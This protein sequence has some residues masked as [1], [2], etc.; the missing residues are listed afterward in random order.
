MKPANVFIQL[1]TAAVFL[2]SASAMAADRK[3]YS[4]SMCQPNQPSNQITYLNGSAF[5]TSTSRISV[6]CPIVRDNTQNTDGTRS[7][8]VIVQSFGGQS[9]TCSLFSYDKNAINIA[10]KTASTTSTAP[11]PLNVDV[12]AG[13]ELGIYWINCS[14]PPNSR[15][16]NYDIDEF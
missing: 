12:N 4:G 10:Q 11:F 13:A 16:L 5:N 3:T 6:T 14:L 2:S 15:V 7:A 1:F 8:S 9:V